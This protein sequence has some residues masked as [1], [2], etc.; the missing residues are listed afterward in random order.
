MHLSSTAFSSPTPYPSSFLCPGTTCTILLLSKTDFCMS[1][2]RYSSSP[3][4][5]LPLSPPLVGLCAR[6]PPPPHQ[7]NSDITGLH[8]QAAVPKY[9]R[10]E[11]QPA[12][13]SVVKAAGAGAVEQI[14]RVTNSLQVSCV[15]VFFFFYHSSK[16]KCVQRRKRVHPDHN[17]L[18]DLKLAV[19][20]PGPRAADDQ[21]KVEVSRGC[22]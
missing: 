18:S 20:T 1:Y 19:L 3:Y 9:L 13:G 11:M 16:R 7:N 10:L 2:D 8:F 12:S 4:S 21:G 5:L 17:A 6:H 22:R 15:C 14:V